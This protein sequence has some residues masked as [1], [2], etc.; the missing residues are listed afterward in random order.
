MKSHRK[1]LPSLESLSTL[2]SNQERKEGGQNGFSPTTD[3]E[4]KRS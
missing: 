1:S 3:Q 4:E 2:P